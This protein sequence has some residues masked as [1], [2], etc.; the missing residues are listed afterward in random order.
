MITPT[1]IRDFAS[2]AEVRAL[3]S[4][5]ESGSLALT[6]FRHSAHLAVGLAYLADGTLA[7]ATARM[8]EGLHRFLAHH[9]QDGAYHETLTLFWMRLLDHLARNCYVHQP[10]WKRVNAVARSHGGSWSVAAHYSPERTGLAE[11]RQRWVA[12]DLL[13]LPF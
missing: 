5:F 6:E 2:D 11:A 10:L 8:R 12:P 3:V 4:A 9:Q 7:E 1:K 13:P